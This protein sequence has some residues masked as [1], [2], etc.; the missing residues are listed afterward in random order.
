MATA[1]AALNALSRFAAD[2][3]VAIALS[4]K[5]TCL[6]IKN[7][8][9]KVPLMLCFVRGKPLALLARIR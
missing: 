4:A 6:Y 7:V 1:S 3:T 5:L 2:C 9:I 8:P